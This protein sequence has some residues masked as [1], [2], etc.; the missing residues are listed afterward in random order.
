M[1]IGYLVFNVRQM[2]TL[3]EEK[4]HNDQDKQRSSEGQEH[5]K[6]ML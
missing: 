3:K 4:S 1:A 2:V 5:V 6:E